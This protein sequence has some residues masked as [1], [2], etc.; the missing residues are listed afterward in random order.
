MNMQRLISRSPEIGW[1][2]VVGHL[3]L[4]QQWQTAPA[5]VRTQ[6]AEVFDKIV[7][8]APRAFPSNASEEVQS[9]MQEQ[10]LKALAEQSEPQSRTPSSTDVDI[11][12]AALDTLLRLLESHGHS[13][14]CGWTPIFDILSLACPPIQVAAGSGQQGST[15]N[16]PTV[17]SVQTSSKSAATLLRVA[18]PSLQLICSDFLAALS[19]EELQMCINTLAGFGKQTEDV[20]VALTVSFEGDAMRNACKPGTVLTTRSFR[21]C[22]YRLAASCGKFPTSCR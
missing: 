16:V 7:T 12:K 20:N 9:A 10:I 4:V 11:R 14:L 1:D 6:A 8:E 21:M 5:E 22:G 13:L 3:L 17:T 18:F 19:T 15:G 2:V